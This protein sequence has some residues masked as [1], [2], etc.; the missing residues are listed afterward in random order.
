[1]THPDDMTTTP[2][3]GTDMT[4]RGFLQAGG[5]LA[6]GAISLPYFNR[7]PRSSGGTF[8]FYTSTNHVYETWKDVISEFE[9]DNDVS[10][11]W[12]KY[13]WADMQTKLQA[14]FT[15]G[16]VPD[17]V[18]YQ[19]GA[20]TMQFV[21]TDDVAPLDSFIDDDGEEIGFPD[22]W[23]QQAVRA[24]QHEGSTYGIQ[25]QLTCAQLYY[26]KRLL[27]EAGI[28]SPPETWDDFL[29]AAQELTSDDV[30]GTSLHATSSFSWPWILQAGAQLF[31]PDSGEF[32]APS[33]ASIEAL[34]FQQDLVHRYEVSNEPAATSDFTVARD[35]FTAERVAMI[36]TGPWDIKP[37]RTGN[38]DL[39][40]AIGL[41]LEGAER[42]TNFAGS[43]VFIPKQ[44]GQ[45]DLAW[46]LT[47]RLTSLETQ[48]AL[49]AEAGQTMPRKSWAEDPQ[50]A[51][52]PLLAN[53]AAALQYAED[54][55]AD[56]AGTGALAEVDA[57]YDTLYQEV[58]LR[59][60]SPADAIGSF[61]DAAKRALD[62]S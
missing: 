24:W 32:L 45:P 44:A 38:P 52:D 14:D 50:V 11:N 55:G 22:D 54:W 62:A 53:I 17:L 25:L 27:D 57:A 21:V 6:L 58:V 40:L 59:A 16:T 7:L 4:R 3:T 43:G 31:N 10:V 28:S 39:E 60:S 35:L 36:F 19:G 47:R 33:D 13:S 26:N 15:A 23:Q 8:T 46:D 42:S 2:N 51:D 34:Q 56:L 1:M 18:E 41:P 12:Q 29:A 30:Y 49:T 37:I 5:G 48:L 20:A 9:A 61:Q